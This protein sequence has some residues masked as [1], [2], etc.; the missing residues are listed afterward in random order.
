MASVWEI[1]PQYVSNFTLRAFPTKMQMYRALI[2]VAILMK[3]QMHGFF[4]RQDQRNEPLV[5]LRHRQILPP[6]IC[7]TVGNERSKKLT[8]S[9]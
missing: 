5:H 9:G 8:C 1:Q 3:Y 6:Y 7:V 4:K 2:L